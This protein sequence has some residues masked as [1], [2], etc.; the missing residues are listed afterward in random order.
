MSTTVITIMPDYGRAWGWHKR[1]GESGVGRFCAGG[2]W[3]SGPGEVP[4]SLLKEFEIWQATFDD[5][6]PHHAVDWSSF[7]EKG[8]E[9]GLQLRKCLSED[10]RLFYEKPVE[11][12]E[13]TMLGWECPEWL[14][15]IM[16]DGQ[17]R[18]IVDP[19]EMKD[20]R[21][22]DPNDPP[23][24]QNKI[25]RRIVVQAECDREYGNGWAWMGRQGQEDTGICV[26]TKKQ[27]NGPGTP[28]KDLLDSF[29]EWQDSFVNG[30]MLDN[31]EWGNFQK[32]GVALTKQLRQYIPEGV[33]LYYTEP[34]NCFTPGGLENPTRSFMLEALLDGA[35]AVVKFPGKI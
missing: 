16:P 20:L 33:P 12:P 26:G 5:A 1:L 23:R 13:Y 2:D 19:E 30:Y 10:V 3:W 32:R 27:W 31:F 35:M 22:Y 4:T 29:C 21:G 34:S 15:E 6:R 24:S 18:E 11:D 17:V 8:I 14:V 25:L 9:L 28:S 7:Y